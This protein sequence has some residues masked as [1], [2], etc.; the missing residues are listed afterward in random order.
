M[1][2]T[3]YDFIILGFGVTDW[4]VEGIPQVK[5]FG[6]TV[7]IHNSKTLEFGTHTDLEQGSST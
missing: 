2:G 5:A 6:F 1:G 3:V 7:P 4:N